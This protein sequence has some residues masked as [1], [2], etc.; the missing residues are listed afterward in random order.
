LENKKHG[1]GIWKSKPKFNYHSDLYEGEFI[2]DKQ[3]GFG[4]YRWVNGV[5]YRGDFL[6]D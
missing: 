6:D 4:E 5:I 3:C 1:K 2:N